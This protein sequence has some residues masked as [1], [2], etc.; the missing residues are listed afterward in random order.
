MKHF[1]Y[2]QNGKIKFDDMDYFIEDVKA[3]ESKRIEIFIDEYIPKRTISQNKYYRVL[4]KYLSEAT[5]HTSREMGLEMKKRFLKDINCNVISTADLTKKEFTE[6]LDKVIQF[7]AE[8]GI[9]LPAINEL[10]FHQLTDK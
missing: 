8:Q 1:A 9:I 3:H 4:L 10:S 6:Y 7:G 5:G 2:I